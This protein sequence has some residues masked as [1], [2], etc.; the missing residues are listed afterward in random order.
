MKCGGIL[1]KRFLCQKAN[2]VPKFTAFL[3]RCNCLRKA[4]NLVACFWILFI[5]FQRSKNFLIS[6]PNYF[7]QPRGAWSI[8]G[9][10][11]VRLPKPPRGRNMFAE[12][13]PELDSRDQLNG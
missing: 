4:N 7:L 11:Q 9:S 12:L 3:N 13:F 6:F 8:F 1:K 2:P 10:E 5:V